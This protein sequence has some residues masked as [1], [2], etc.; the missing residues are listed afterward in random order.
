[1]PR[2]GASGGR[3]GKRTKKG[4]MR[5]FT[6]PEELQAQAEHDRKQQEWRKKQGIESEEEDEDAARAARRDLP[7]TDSSEEDSSDDDGAR[8]KGVSHLIEIENPNRVGGR[9]SKK[10]SELED[11]GPQLSRREREVLEKQR[12]TER[13]NKLHMEGKTDEARADL[14]RLALI[15]Q[16]REEASKRREAERLK[17]EKEKEAKHRK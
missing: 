5:H 2:G 7:P 17:A 16:Q 1:M 14:A 13:Y 15:R 6:S 12:A 11:T 8:A 10:I 4:R 3:G 9:T